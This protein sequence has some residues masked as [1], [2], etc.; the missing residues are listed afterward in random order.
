MTA[1]SSPFRP[2]GWGAPV[3]NSNSPRRRSTIRNSAATSLTYYCNL[4]G[5]CR[6]CLLPTLLSK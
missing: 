2:A 4:L 6:H 3:N 1:S 5:T